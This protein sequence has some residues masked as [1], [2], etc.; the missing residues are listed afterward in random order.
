[1]IKKKTPVSEK[2]HNFKLN[3]IPH[4]KGVYIVGGSVRDALL[5][6]PPKDYDIAV[7]GDARPVAEEIARR[8]GRRAVPIGKPGKRIFRV[9]SESH[10]Y[11]IIPADE[12]LAA[13]LNRRDFSIN[14]MA[15]DV[16]DQK[17]IDP[18]NG[19]S[20]LDA[21]TIRMTDAGIFE[22]DPLRLLRAFRIAAGLTFDI[23]PETMTEIERN[24]H[25]ITTVAGERVRDEWVRLLEAPGSSAYLRK[26]DGTGLL[27]ALFPELAQ[28]KN[29]RQNEHHAFDMFEHT[30]EV[31]S[32][33]EKALD[34]D[35]PRLHDHHENAALVSGPSGS[36]LI[37]HAA[38][39]H[40]I[41][42]P[43]VQ[44]I[45][46][47]G[48]I[49]FFGHEKTGAAMSND[50]STRLRFSTAQKNYA[51][52]LIRHHLRPLFLF[53][54]LSE[55]RRKVTARTRFYMKTFPFTTDLVLLSTADMLGKD[56]TRDISGYLNFA[57][58]TI[59]NYFDSYLPK[60]NTPRFV[61]GNDLIERFDL[62]PSPFLGEVLDKLDILHLS[63]NITTREEALKAAE[64]Y[65][66][67]K[68]PT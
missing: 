50:I 49:H 58:E 61:T 12:G 4:Q 52:F 8:A 41:G 7:T 46:Q 66:N 45:D 23:S 32:R 26:M 42:K 48:K 53:L 14:A 10:I 65:I 16:Y 60:S 54:A 28:L 62:L 19:Q 63:G 6:H 17:L 44:S 57:R 51:W 18:L 36:A 55:G 25:A 2:M 27:G 21:R 43:M 59:E 39:F 5:G 15:Y 3:F 40:D 35:I 11:D 37:K 29:R 34:M 1:M 64:I 56:K 38:L 67:S 9:V 24:P 30:L 20:D 47:Q 22:A 33:L 13:D 31:Y 68:N